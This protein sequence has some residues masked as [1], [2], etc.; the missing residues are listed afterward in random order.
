MYENS[1]LGFGFLVWF[2]AFFGGDG[3]K[4]VCLLGFGGGSC[5][6][7]WVFCVWGF[8]RFVFNAM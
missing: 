1:D 3:E 7:V 8:L 4:L 5:C 6:W 2:W